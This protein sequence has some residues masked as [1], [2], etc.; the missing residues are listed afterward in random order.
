MFNVWKETEAF[1]KLRHVGTLCFHWQPDL[2]STARGLEFFQVSPDRQK[3][4]TYS[5]VC[6]NKT[7][8]VLCENGTS[9]LNRDSVWVIWNIITSNKTIL[10]ETLP[11]QDQA[12]PIV[13]SRK[14]MDPSL[15]SQKPCSQ[16]W[17][18]LQFF[19]SWNKQETVFFLVII[20]LDSVDFFFLIH[21]MQQP[22]QKG[23]T[24]CILLKR[25][26]KERSGWTSPIPHLRAS[27]PKLLIWTHVCGSCY[28]S[29][30]L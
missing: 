3:C 13:S 5:D 9:G 19:F 10:N 15:P 24:N 17:M 6:F 12:N 1:S 16:S 2:K 4:L 18:L 26:M 30:A 8:A 29:S 11:L 7:H 25:R 28:V 27:F 20:L 23:E 14:L 21:L 22:S